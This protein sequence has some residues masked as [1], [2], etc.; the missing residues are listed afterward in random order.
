[1]SRHIRSYHALVAL[2]SPH[3]TGWHDYYFVPKSDKSERFPFVPSSFGAQTQRTPRTKEAS[4]AARIRKVPSQ[5][6][7]VVSG[8]TPDL[9]FLAAVD[10]VV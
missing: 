2:C 4:R 9:G 8:H 5:K 3:R 10:C 6:T 1:M 7:K